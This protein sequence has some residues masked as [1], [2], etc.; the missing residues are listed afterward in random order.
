MI[1]YGIVIF[2]LLRIR[3]GALEEEMMALHQVDV[4]EVL[5]VLID[6]ARRRKHGCFVRE[7]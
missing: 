5:W 7:L 6:L 2:F 3:A 4:R 1:S